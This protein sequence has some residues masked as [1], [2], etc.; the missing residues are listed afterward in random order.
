MPDRGTR[1]EQREISVAALNALDAVI[2]LTVDVLDGTTSATTEE[3][4]ELAS[5]LCKARGMVLE[6]R[7]PG[8]AINAR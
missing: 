5:E 4:R 1:T 6:A 2:D 3:C 7:E 8:E